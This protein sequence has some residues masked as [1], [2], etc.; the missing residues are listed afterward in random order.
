LLKEVEAEQK[1]L[2]AENKKYAADRQVYV[3]NAMREKLINNKQTQTL[4]QELQK[5]N[6][7]AKQKLTSEV[8]RTRS[9]KIGNMSLFDEINQNQTFKK[10]KNEEDYPTSDSLKLSH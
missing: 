6:V 7:E 8:I 5:K 1:K 9:S 10:Y 4:S 3:A 2:D